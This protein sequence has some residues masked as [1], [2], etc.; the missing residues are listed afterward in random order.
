M[1]VLE[2]FS[3]S[4]GHIAAGRN[5]SLLATTSA[6][7]ASA[8]LYRNTYTKVEYEHWDEDDD[9]VGRDHRFVYYTDREVVR[10][11]S[12]SI[13]A[14][15]TLTITGATLQNTTDRSNTS[16]L[17][18]RDTA[19]VAGAVVA[20]SESAMF[21]PVTTPGHHYLIETNP[22]LTNLGNFYGSDYFLSRIG[23]DQKNSRLCCWAM[24]ITKRALY[25]SRF[26]KARAN[27]FCT[28]TAL[29][30]TRCGASW[31]RR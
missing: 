29:T 30:Q 9:Y 2:A 22:A 25:S 20:L 3:N 21:H 19:E 5:L 16:P 11:F 10:P 27:A 28:A 23:L 8:A 14:G 26:C 15:D 31:T 1:L 4:T 12:A 6:V 17:T 24:P 7:N 13:T 18:T